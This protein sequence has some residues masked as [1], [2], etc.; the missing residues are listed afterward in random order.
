M[1]VLNEEKEFVAYV[2]ELMQSVGSVHAKRM[3]GGHGIFLEGHMF[4]LVA[5]D[6]LYLKA[7]EETRDDFNARGLEAF[8]YNKKG[9]EFKLS[10]FQAPEETLDDSDEMNVWANKAYSTAVRAAAK[11]GKKGK[12]G[13][14]RKGLT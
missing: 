10:Y 7:D 1:P 14:E 9:K 13:K 6:V 5:G 11:K 2:V 4:G 12:K 8:T 3:F